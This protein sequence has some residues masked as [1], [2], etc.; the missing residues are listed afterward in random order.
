MGLLFSQATDSSPR[1]GAA[2]PQGVPRLLAAEWKRVL[3]L[4]L[5]LAVDWL[6]IFG[7]L[8]LSTA[9]R[10]LLAESLWPQLGP[11][12][13]LKFYLEASLWLA[14]LTI[15]LAAVKLYGRRFLFWAEAQAVVK[16]V[17]LG[18]LMLVF[19]SFA[20]DPEHSMSRLVIALFFVFSA[21]TLPLSRYAL[22]R[23]MWKAGLWRKRVLLVGHNQDARH[24]AA[25]LLDNSSLAYQPVAFVAAAGDPVEN[26]SNHPDTPNN[27]PVLGPDTDLGEAIRKLDARD[28]I[29]CLAGHSSE[30]LASI[31]TLVEGKAETVLVV[32]DAM[33]LASIGVVTQDVGGHLLLAMQW[34]LA[35]PWNLAIKRTFDLLV[36]TSVLS[37][38]WPLMLLVALAVRMDSRGPA[39]FGQRR[40]GRGDRE[41]NCLKF[42][43]LHENSDDLLREHLASDPRSAAEW[44]VYAKLRGHDPRVTR[45]GRWL[46]LLDIDELPQLFNVLRGDMSLVGPRPYLESEREQRGGISQTILRAL[47]GMTGLWQ[48]SGRNRLSFSDRN[49]I[50]EYYVRNWSLWMDA[51]I[52]LRTLA[53]LVG[54]QR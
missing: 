43:S 34:S 47:P 2:A 45:V 40:I 6:V 9:T 3:V 19:I 32:P 20:Q 10:D 35:K 33:G 30:E 29:V 46:R 16:G 5:L 52:I 37:L 36:A 41:F 27:L 54:K 18:C 13:S 22:K 26:E 1:R 8:V 49:R 31:L 24:I 39:L 17:A 53:H 11:G 50:D 42:R 7:C 44:Q 28:V 12:W 48:V 25:C 51:T 38:C 4:T 14:P 15:S 21:A 23:L